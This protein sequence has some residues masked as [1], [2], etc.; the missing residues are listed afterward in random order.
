MSGRNIRRS[1]EPPP[2]DQSDPLRDHVNRDGA[3]RYVSVAMV[4]VALASILMT[5]ALPDHEEVKA[6]AARTTRADQRILG[7]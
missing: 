2:Q 6:A 1:S 4:T 7:G 5:F 3:S